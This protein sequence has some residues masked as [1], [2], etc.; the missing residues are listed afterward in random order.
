MV[1][2]STLSLRSVAFVDAESDGPRLGIT[3]KIDEF[4][5]GPPARRMLSAKTQTCC[6]IDPA[7]MTVTINIW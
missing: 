3:A 2:S 6:S 5:K 1:A 4:E 7:S